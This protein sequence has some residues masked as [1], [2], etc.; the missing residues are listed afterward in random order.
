[1]IQSKIVKRF[2]GLAI[3]VLMGLQGL[4]QETVFSQYYNNPVY[5]NPGLIGADLGMK[6]RF[7]Y[8][9]QWANL[10]GDFKTLNFNMDI[11]ERNIPGSGGLAVMFNRKQEGQGF[12]EKTVIGVG[13][14]VRIPLQEN[15][16]THLGF[17]GSFVEQ[18]VNWDNLV[19][20]DEFDNRYGAIYPTAFTP[21]ASGL[22]TVRYPDIVIGNILRF[23][24]NAYSVD[25]IV[26]TV[27]LAVHH[28]LE[29][30][31]SY[32]GLESKVPRKYVA[33]GNLLWIDQKGNNSRDR[34]SFS[35][36]TKWD[37]GFLFESWQNRTNYAVGVN[38]MRS[39]LYLGAWYRG[40]SYGD[41][42][43]DAM[44]FMLG[45]NY[46]MADNEIMKIMYSYDWD[47][48]D[49]VS[50]SG[51]T[52]ELT[53]IFQLNDVMMFG[54]SENFSGRNYGGSYGGRSSGG[55]IQQPLECSPF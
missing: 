5:Y 11:A 6:M 19:F 3:M 38:V 32:L 8:R 7:Q 37:F 35:G 24:P 10:P 47:L 20:S 27:G 43:S 22:G 44:V 30:D 40:E 39:N 48:N 51:P 14:S 9:D 53:L 21:P 54:K 26:G 12:L 42:D 16:V 55:I 50:I 28:T 2:A 49:L 17:M 13:T 46:E 52:H 34:D 15:V 33:H 25:K 29:P 4:S 18:R 36:I 23:F 31:D 1:M 41:F 45:V